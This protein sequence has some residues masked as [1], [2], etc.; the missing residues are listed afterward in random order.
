MKR[1]FATGLAI[2]ACMAITMIAQPKLEI[3]GGDTHDWGKVSPKDTP[4]KTVVKIKNVGTEVLKITDVH[5]GCGCTK[6]AELDKKELQPGETATTE[7]SL[8]LGAANGV[9]TKS[10]TITSNDATAPTK[11]LY[12]KADVVRPIQFSPSQYFVFNDLK[13]GQTSEAKVTIKNT[14]KE[15]ITLSDFEALNGLSVN[16][17][18]PITIKGGSE[19]E[20]IGRVTPKEKGYFNGSLKM[21][22]TNPENPTI[23][24]TAYGNVAESTSPIYPK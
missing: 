8:N 18:K 3:V 10:V 20:I 7:L 19:V 1:F 24:I 13:A 22:T 21:K 15:D 6:T 14:S 2:F 4:L 17:K 23:E 9:L 11:I 16:L 5:P 12:L